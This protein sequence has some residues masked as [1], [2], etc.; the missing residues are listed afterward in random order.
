MLR[1]IEDFLKEE[2]HLK[3]KKE[4]KA[5]EEQVMRVGNQ[6]IADFLEKSL[7]SS[8]CIPITSI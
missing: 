3:P 5:P 8:I 6:S 2:I 1:N 7:P 4:K